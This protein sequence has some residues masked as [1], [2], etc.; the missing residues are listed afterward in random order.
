MA[1]NHDR[2]QALYVYALAKAASLDGSG[3]LGRIHLLKYAYLADL[4]H[5]SR[6]QGDPFSGVE[7]RFYHFG[8]WSNNALQQIE[9]TVHQFGAKEYR[10]ASQYDDDFV[11]YGFD[12][13]DADEIA[14]RLERDLPWVVQNAIARAV[15]EHGTNTADLL[16]YVYLTP[17]MLAARPGDT[18]DL[19]LMIQHSPAPTEE[20]SE[21]HKPT[22]SEKRRRAAAVEAAR[23]EIRKRLAAA[24]AKR[25][26]PNPA[27]RYDDVFYAGT[28]ELDKL[29]GEPPA[30]SSGELSFDDS[31]W[32]SEQRRGPD[33]S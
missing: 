28:A 11:R 14:S 9:P 29:A 8:P 18:L 21:E 5:A 3:L 26:M 17:P 12:R 30:P 4:A 24:A 23:A 1:G 33:V 13:R 6:N 10:F 2:L 25:V 31:V 7:W 27:P 32:A 16:R 19:R 20:T 15:A 22:N